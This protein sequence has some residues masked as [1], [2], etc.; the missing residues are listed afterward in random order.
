M[1]LIVLVPVLI[2][3][4]MHWLMPSLVPHTLPFGVRVPADHA[5]DPVVAAQRR[6]YRAGTVVVT[7]AAVAA[8]VAIVAGAGRYA[9]ALP[10]VVGAQ[11]VV[12]VLLYL[13]ARRRIRA[14]KEAE[15]WFGGRR[16][17]V[18]T[19][20]SLR[21]RPEPY[22]WRWA[23]PAAVLLVATAVTGAVGYPHMPARIPRHLGPDGIAGRYVDRSPL[24][25]LAPW[26]GQAVITLVLLGVAWALLR[27][28]PRLD[29]EADHAAERHRRF[30]A[31]MAR[32]LL[33]LTGCI[34]VTY[35]FACL[36]SWGLFRPPRPIMVVLVGGPVL[37][38]LLALVT[39]LVHT[40]Q[41]GSRLR[42]P[43]GGHDRSGAPSGAVN[44][45][46]DRL[47]RGGLI[48]FNRD[49]P[50]LWVPKRFGVGWTVN[51]A[52]PAAWALIAA[53]AALVAVGPLLEFLAR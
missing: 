19:D 15:D 48:Y 13:A 50:A 18:A 24:V 1:T 45:D 39:V 20:T 38:G 8:V 46:D 5:D 44:R 21:T 49:D 17:V 12:C 41:G 51:M 2:I 37:A 31:A 7:A 26:V 36:S 4:V 10:P 22:P 27:S 33:A 14:V 53:L 25:V 52:R 32:A 28:S 34:N 3:G 42:M 35:L 9:P 29:V 30:V 23:L 40:G 16:Q 43:G 11:L 6:R 47:Y